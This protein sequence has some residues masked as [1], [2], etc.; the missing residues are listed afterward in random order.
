MAFAK[1]V[2][3]GDKVKSTAPLLDEGVY[4]ARILS[5]V[6][7]GMQPGSPQYPEEKLKLEFRFE[8]LDEFMLDEEGKVLTDKPRV[9]S[10]EVT[11]NADGYMNEK[12]NIYKLIS[13]IPEGFTMSLSEMIGT[14]VNVMISKYIKK[15]GKNA[16]KEDNKVVSVLTMKA[17]EVAAAPALINTPLFFD[18]AEPTM[19]AWNKLYSG[20]KYAQRD[21]IMASSSFQGS[22]IQKMLGATPEE[23]SDSNEDDAPN[24]L[25]DEDVDL[26]ADVPY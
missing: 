23:V 25:V 21:R 15:S 12:A 13:A 3:A 4:P 14:P 10:Y 2:K 24:E 9:F 11:Y 18:M 8:L 6:D 19:E 7:L 17:K 5:I 20:N 16:G 1:P 26:D 22:L